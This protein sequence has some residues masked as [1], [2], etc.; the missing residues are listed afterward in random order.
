M[1]GVANISLGLQAVAVVTSAQSRPL[2]V[3]GVDLLQVMS[4]FAFQTLGLFCPP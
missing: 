1:E 2:L 4:P 3:A